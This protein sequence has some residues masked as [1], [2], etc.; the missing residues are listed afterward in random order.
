MPL[1]KIR[2]TLSEKYPRGTVINFPTTTLETMARSA[3][4]DDA[5]IEDYFEILDRS[6]RLPFGVKGRDFD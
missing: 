4:G 1:V 5:E 3:G 6:A 2:K